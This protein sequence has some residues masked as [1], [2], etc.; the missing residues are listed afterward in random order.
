MLLLLQCGLQVVKAS[1]LF[2]HYFL[3]AAVAHVDDVESRLGLGK[4]LALDVESSRFAGEKSWG[5]A[6]AGWLAGSDDD[7][8]VVVAVGEVEVGERC[9]FG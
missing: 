6:D 8:I 3:H 5:A 4:A 1:L 7:G 2:H 9:H